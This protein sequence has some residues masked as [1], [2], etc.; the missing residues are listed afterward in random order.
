MPALRLIL[1]HPAT[2]GN[3]GMA[4]TALISFKDLAA[5]LDVRRET[6][7]DIV[8]KRRLKTGKTYGPAKGLGPREVRE[9]RKAL[10][11][12]AKAVPA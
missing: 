3:P 8:R 10:G 6:I 7:S 9:V 4:S 5:E 12:A 1:P 2:E 11:M